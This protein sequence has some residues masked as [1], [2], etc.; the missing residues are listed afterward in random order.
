[1]AAQLLSPKLKAALAKLKPREVALVVGAAIIASVM[2]LYSYVIEPTQAAFERQSAA[3]KTLATTAD[4]APSILARYLKIAERRKEIEQFY[5]KV[6]IRVDPLTHL[7]KLLREV[8]H[9]S[10][11]SYTVSPRD[12]VQ[13]GGKYAHKIFMVKFETASLQDLTAFMKA[14]TEGEQPMLLSMVNLEKRLTSESLAVQIE[15]S[16]FEAVS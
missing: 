2:F 3:F 4:V 16:G 15:V 6:D 8:A 1:M 10:P 11:G 7:E 5:D 13:L 12:G 9:V 14:V